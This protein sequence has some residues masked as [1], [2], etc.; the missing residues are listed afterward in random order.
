MNKRVQELI[1]RKPSR[2][3]N[4]S[5]KAFQQDIRL[6]TTT[7]QKQQTVID[8]IKNT[9][10]NYRNEAIGETDLALVDKILDSIKKLNESSEKR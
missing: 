5:I 10:N 9:C 6:L 3:G 4:V 2:W 8:G 1:N 7:V